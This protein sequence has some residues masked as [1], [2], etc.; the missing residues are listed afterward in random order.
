M[1]TN[2]K[3]AL[4]GYGLAGRHFHRPLIAAT[5]GLE[6]SAVMTANAE[7]REQAAGDLP[8][9][10]ILDS[11]DAVWDRAGDFDL[12]V[13]AGANL[14]HLPYTVGALAHGLPAVVD[15]PLAATAADAMTI[16]DAAHAAGKLVF[17]FQ[18][19]RWDSEFLTILEHQEAVGSIHRFESHF[20][21]FR[22]V[23]KGGWRELAD[24]SA[25][26]GVLLDFGAH[27]VDQGIQLLG[28]VV[29][30]Y[31]ITRSVRA[32]EAAEDDM[33]IL[34]THASGAVSYLTGSLIAAFTEPRFNVLGTRGGMLLRAY[35]TQEEEL[36][37]GSTPAD[38]GWGI[39]PLSS[40]AVIRVAGPDGS[41]IESE[42]QLTPG[43]WG[44][45]YA[46]VYD[47]INKAAPPPVLLDDA[48]ANL[49]VL[50]AARKSATTG[51]A[52]SLDPPAAHG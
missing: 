17:P 37:A 42:V 16:R 15:K 35:D 50:D 11:V 22:T 33:L 48:I 6:I 19:R 44:T 36:R 34:L 47:A 18:N 41:T 43:R 14:T 10:E 25:I 8:A 26:G 28:P 21:R 32:A 7:R 13:V 9:A 24:P 38:A 2:L 4:L 39:E 1:P 12:V 5:A 29:S 46:G 49:R 40:A 20:D 51:L 31:A 27:L 52:I 23:P 45:F 30:V 3:I